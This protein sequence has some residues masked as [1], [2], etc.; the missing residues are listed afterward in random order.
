MFFRKVSD[1]EKRALILNLDECGNIL[2]V[3]EEATSTQVAAELLA[4]INSSL[5]VPGDLLILNLG[6]R[7]FA[8]D[9]FV[10]L[11]NVFLNAGFVI[12]GV[13]SFSQETR[14]LS[15]NLGIKA[16]IGRM[17]ISEHYSRVLNESSNR[18]LVSQSCERISPSFLNDSVLLNGSV[19]SGDVF[20]FSDN[21]VIR[22]NIE[23]GSKITARGDIIVLGAIYGEVYAGFAN[24]RDATVTA[25]IFEP[26]LLHIAGVKMNSALLPAIARGTVVNAYLK[27]DVVEVL[28]FR[29]D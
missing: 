18:S 24:N 14:I 7:S 23:K 22:G 6:W 15:E 11:L 12:D 9:E 25:F 3:F 10:E 17:G 28:P 2:S 13:I 26:A 27:G 16:I 4:F 20:E 21:V 5:I 1:M 19:S 29:L 8:Y